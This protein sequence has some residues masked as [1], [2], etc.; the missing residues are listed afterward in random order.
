MNENAYGRKWIEVNI[1]LLN[2]IFRP[3]ARCALR[4]T[5]NR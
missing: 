4:R 5:W 2:C 1:L 3:A